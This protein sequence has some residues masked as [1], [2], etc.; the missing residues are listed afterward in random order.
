MACSP[1]DPAIAQWLT[2]QAYETPHGPETRVRLSCFPWCGG[3]SS[4]AQ[5]ARE[6]T[7]RIIGRRIS[8]EMI[9]DDQSK[10]H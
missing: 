7:A 8:T 6:K 10:G 5:N 2:R 3:I 9:D 4:G 1:G